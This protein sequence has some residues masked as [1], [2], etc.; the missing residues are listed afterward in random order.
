MITLRLYFEMGKYHATEWGRN[1]NEGIV[2]WPPSP[3]RLLRAIISSWKTHHQDI[4]EDVMW[5]ILQ[6]MITNTVSFK[7]PLARVAHTRHYVPVASISQKTKTIKT[8]KILDTFIIVGNEPIFAIWK[9]ATLDKVQREILSDI[10]N[11]IRY[12]G[13]S[14]SL[15]RVVFFEGDVIPNCTPMNGVDGGDDVE[16]ADV[17]VPKESI[18]L[19]K[20]CVRTGVLKSKKR[21]YPTETEIIPYVRPFGCLSAIPNPSDHASAFSVAVV[22]YAITGKPRPL[23]TDTIVIGDSFKRAA[24]SIYGKLYDG[25]MS[26]VLSGRQSDDGNIL[27]DNHSHAFFLPTDEDNDNRL[28]HMTVAVSSKH[29]FDQKVTNALMKIKRVQHG[30]NVLQITHLARGRQENFTLAPI[31]QCLSLIHI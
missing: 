23:V 1:V 20:L 28:D 26:P 29:T 24:M 18:S 9:D 13:R 4:P 10:L 17:L 14:E 7:L 31:L 22:R 11:D 19:E 6:T 30:H 5:V 3:W 12:I 16:I 8:E 25:A 27:L 21:I 2:D 15:C